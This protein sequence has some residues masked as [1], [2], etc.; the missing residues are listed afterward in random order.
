[1][2]YV[3]ISKFTLA[4][5]VGLLRLA[6]VPIVHDAYAVTVDIT[7]GMNRIFTATAKPFAAAIAATIFLGTAV[8]AETPQNQVTLQP[9]PPAFDYGSFAGEP[10]DVNYGVGYW[11][12]IATNAVVLGDYR[13]ALV[14]FDKALDLA[15]AGA[16]ELLEQRGWVHFRLGQYTFAIADLRTATAL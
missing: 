4:A 10:G 16:P 12:E 3:P 13:N 1:M 2:S 6:G 9:F 15:G 5:D 7:K 8:R 11:Q 14:S